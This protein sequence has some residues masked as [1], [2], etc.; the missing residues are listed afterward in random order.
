MAAIGIVQIGDQI[1]TTPARRFDLPRESAEAGRVITAL[2]TK[3]RLVEQLH[4]FGRGGMGLAAPQ[5]GVGRAAAVYR[6]S[7]RPQVVLVNPVVVEASDPESDWDE[8]SEGCLSFFD[9]RGFVA[10][11][12]TIVVEHQDLDGATVRSVFAHEREARDVLHEIDHL[13]G[14]LYPDRMAEA[15]KLVR[16]PE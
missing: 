16:A 6:P 10:R 5:I 13:N 1:L 7:Y 2:T 3:A 14:V 15:A 8:D 9:Y 4:A 12:K 11:P